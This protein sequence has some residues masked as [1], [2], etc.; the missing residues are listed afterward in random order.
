MEENFSTEK[1]VIF[2]GI[3][4]AAAAIESHSF[5][6]SIPNEKMNPVLITFGLCCLSYQLNTNESWICITITKGGKSI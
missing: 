3:G 5:V 1:S 2:F 4:I 6:Y